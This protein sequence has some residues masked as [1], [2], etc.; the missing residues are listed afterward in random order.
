[1]GTGPGSLCQQHG[2]CRQTG[3][4]RVSCVALDRWLCLSGSQGPHLFH[5]DSDATLR[6]CSEGHWAQKCAL[7][8]AGPLP[9]EWLWAGTWKTKPPVPFRAP[10]SAP[11]PRPRL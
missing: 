5:G 9:P 10:S 4:G 1:M 3:C 7:V 6:G 11:T 8:D 2:A